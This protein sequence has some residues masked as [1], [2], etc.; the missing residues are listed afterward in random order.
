MT[1]SR[2]SY[3]TKTLTILKYCYWGYVN[4]SKIRKTVDRMTHN[5]ILLVLIRA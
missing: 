1:F 3:A 2:R 4:V 5:V